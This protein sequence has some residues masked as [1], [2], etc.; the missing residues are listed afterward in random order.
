MPQLGMFRASLCFLLGACLA[1]AQA[2]DIEKQYSATAQK[3]IDAALADS[4]GLARLQ[5]LCDRIGAR[6]AGSPALERAAEWSSVEMKK[7]GLVNVRMPETTVPHWV[8]GKESV[9][10]L[11][12]IERPLLMLGL[13]MS[14]GTPPEGITAEVV[15]VASFDEL[16]ALGRDKVAGKI[17]LFNPDWRGYGETVI[18]RA[19]GGSRAAELGAVGALVRSMTGHSLGTPHTGALNYTAG[20]VKIPV[21]AVTVEDA[22]SMHRLIKSGVTVRVRLMMEAKQLPDAISHNVVGEIRGSEKP[23]EVVVLGGHM[24]S[25]DVGQGAQD[26]GS[27][28]I[29]AFQA[30]ALIQK[31]G[32][33]PRRTIRIGLWTGEEEGL[34]GSAAYVSQHFGE[35]ERGNPGVVPPGT[36]NSQPAA[37]RK[38]STKPDYDKLDAYFNLDNGTGKIRGV[39][40]QG[41][42]GVRAIFREWLTP[43]RDLGAETLSISNTGGTDHLSFDRIGLPG[44]QFI[45][46]EIEYDTR[47]HHSNQDVFDRIQGDDLKQA[48]TIMAAFLYNTAMRDEKLPRKPMPGR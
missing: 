33:K 36:A 18:Y 4:E 43:F 19:S 14:V 41:N 46:D 32:L 48:A 26:D 8:R 39:Y 16:T 30:V 10:M 38:L 5:F 3:L 7:A 44:F 47:T 24:D 31:L 27:G 22:A 45:Q 42:E 40:L 29:A 35:F 13:G 25:W 15:A 37:P 34:L 11:S 6:L 1:N 9:T 20:V 23:D 21:A 2:V 17:V 28:M 12:P